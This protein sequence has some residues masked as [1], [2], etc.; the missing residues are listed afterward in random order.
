MVRRRRLVL[1]AV[2]LL[3]LAV[4][5]AIV[6]GRS[7][8]T[9]HGVSVAMVAPP[10]VGAVLSERIEAADPS[11]TVVTRSTTEAA[12]D[13]LRDG[14]VEAV[15]VV[16]L[17]ADQDRLLLSPTNGRRLDD[18]IADGVRDV[19]ATLGRT[20]AV[21][22]VDLPV[23]SRG[24]VAGLVIGA[25]LLGFLAAVAAAWRRGAA[26]DESRGAAT[27]IGALTAASLAGGLLVA[28]VATISGGAFL[29]W[30]L[31]GTLLV[32]AG[33]A[34]TTALLGLI[35]APGAGVSTALFVL[36]AA[37]L[38]SAHHLLLLAEP[39]AAILP[40]LPLGAGLATGSALSIGGSGPLQPWL[41]LAAWV[42]LATATTAV[43]R[44]L[45]VRAFGAPQES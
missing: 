6:L 33:A 30:W 36:A 11:A 26:E 32:G 1:G 4:L 43:A 44:V 27:R 10:V 5:V 9:P 42:V 39:W 20:V 41:V 13:E 45:R 37:P 15:V 3:Q 16:D 31:L 2:L 28:G 38:V 29:P 24:L 34:T 35:G 17:T 18:G 19:S 25:E 40:W 23:V 14:L 8:G 12:L 21:E 7:D 22:R